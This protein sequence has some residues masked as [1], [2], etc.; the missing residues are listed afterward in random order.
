MN[1]VPP[2]D[3]EL[4]IPSLAIPD[5]ETAFR[6]VGKWLRQE[7]G[8]SALYP[9]KAVFLPESFY[10][11]VSVWYSTPTEPLRAF[12]ADIYIHAATGAFLGR[13]TREELVQR[14]ERI[15]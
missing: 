2:N 15:Q 13:P 4:A 7:I 12:M 9:A 6:I 10:W 8:S 3:A 5:A 11:D 1:I 14:L